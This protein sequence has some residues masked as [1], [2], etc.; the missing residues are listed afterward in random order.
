MF[1]KAQFKGLFWPPLEPKIE[2]CFLPISC[3][4]F[5]RRITQV[6]IF[7]IYLTFTIAMVTKMDNKIGLIEKMP[8]WT[9]FKA[10]GDRLF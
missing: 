3:D 5:I 8:F 1:V 4:W 7:G 6:Y 2:C 9:K 10:L